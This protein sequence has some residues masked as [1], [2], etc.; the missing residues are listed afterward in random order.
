MSTTPQGRARRSLSRTALVA[1][2]ATG[3]LATS[4]ALPASAHGDGRGHGR[5]GRVER[6]CDDGNGGIV[7]TMTN[8]DLQLRA[9]VNNTHMT[10]KA[11]GNVGIGF[12]IPSNLARTVID[13]LKNTGKVARGWLGVRIQSVTPE[14]AESLGLPGP[15]G[16]LVASV[17][18]G[19]P[20]ASGSV[21][22]GDVITE[23]DGAA[24]GTPEAFR[25]LLRK[26]VARGGV[27]AF[28]VRR[29]GKASELRVT[30]P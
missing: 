25:T 19:G 24:T 3:A 16:A 18:P 13:S 6:P 29:D 12:A 1:L 17:T 27:G 28:Q 20:A 4:T 30:I 26:R 7:S 22:A 23:F 10:V 9:G 8:H 21:E 14:I 2:V 11:G 5:G 15:D